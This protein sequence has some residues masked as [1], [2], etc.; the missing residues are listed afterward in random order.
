VITWVKREAMWTPAEGALTGLYLGAA[1][2]RL[3]GENVRGLYFHPQS[4]PIV[5]PLANNEVLQDKL[6]DFSEELVKDFLPTDH[7]DEDE[8]EDQQEYEPIDE[9][10]EELS[11]EEQ[12]QQDEELSDEEEWEDFADEE[13]LA[14]EEGEIETEAMDENAGVG[15]ENE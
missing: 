7:T 8:E 12:E 2:D 6:W 4:E 9:E 1:I 3:R 14:D 11:A 13:T 10:V 5:N 15:I